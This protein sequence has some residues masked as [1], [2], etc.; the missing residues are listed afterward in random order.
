MSKETKEIEGK[1]EVY[2]YVQKTVCIHGITRLIRSLSYYVSGEK[3]FEELIEIAKKD[4]NREAQAEAK[5]LDEVK[6]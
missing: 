6:P 5:E 3:S 4:V 2:I 1:E